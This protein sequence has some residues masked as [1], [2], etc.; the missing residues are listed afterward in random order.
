MGPGAFSRPPS[1]FVKATAQRTTGRTW[2]PVS[3]NVGRAGR[4]R[5][6]LYAASAVA[7][8]RHSDAGMVSILPP[9]ISSSDARS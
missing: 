6:E 8:G 5:A 3:G 2:R 7:I 1:L 9:M 4:A